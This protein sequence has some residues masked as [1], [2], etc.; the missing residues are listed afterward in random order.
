MPS[1]GV[2]IAAPSKA[3]AQT[4]KKIDLTTCDCQNP[5]FITHLAVGKNGTHYFM[6]FKSL[7]RIFRQAENRSLSGSIKTLGG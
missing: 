3:K 7:H 6:P 1:S 4:A 5:L 2:G